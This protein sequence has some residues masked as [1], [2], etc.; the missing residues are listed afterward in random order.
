[1]RAPCGGGRAPPAASCWRATLGPSTFRRS[2]FSRFL[3]FYCRFSGR[4][5]CFNLGWLLRRI[6]ASVL[7]M[8]V[9]AGCAIGRR[10]IRRPLCRAATAAATA[11][12]RKLF[13]GTRG[14]DVGFSIRHDVGGS[15]GV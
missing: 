3:I 6:F 12:S 15:L 1:R 9:G 10:A 14:G 8:L 4:L 13:V 7:L 5:N 2:R 11:A